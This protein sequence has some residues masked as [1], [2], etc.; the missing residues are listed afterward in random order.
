LGEMKPKKGEGDHGNFDCL[1]HSYFEHQIEALLDLHQT[2]YR[3]KSTDRNGTFSKQEREALDCIKLRLDS[4]EVSNSE[5][6]LFDSRDR[7]QTI[8]DLNEDLTNL[9]RG[10]LPAAF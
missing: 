1:D 2:V 9:K 3:A 8:Y 4:L 5:L 10:I 7:L 6:E